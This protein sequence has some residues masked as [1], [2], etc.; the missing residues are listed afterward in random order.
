MFTLNFLTGPQ[1]LTFKPCVNLWQWFPTGSRRS[2]YP[3]RV[4]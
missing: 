1:K 4:S 3:Q 2:T